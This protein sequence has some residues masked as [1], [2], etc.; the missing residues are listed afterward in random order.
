[1]ADFSDLATVLA[2][3][4]RKTNPYDARRRYGYGMLQQGMDTSPIASPWQGAARLAQA[5]AGGWAIHNADS[6]EKVADKKR[7]DALAQ[8]MAEPDPQKRIGL[9]AAYDPD[10]GSRMAG[11]LA[12][13][14]YK[15]NAQR[16]Q[17]DTTLARYDMPGGQPQAT[18]MPAQLPTGAPPAGGFNNNAGNIRVTGSRWAGEGAPHNGFKTFATPQDGVNAMVQ[19]YTAY[20]KQNPQIT[21]AQALSKWAPPNENNTGSYIRTITEATGINPGMPLAELMQDPAAFAYFM[22]AQT[23]LEKGGVPQGMTPD[24]F[25]NAAQPRP[26]TPPAAVQPGGL[27]IN[28]PG[29][30]APAPLPVGGAAPPIAGG[31]GSAEIGG[32]PPAPSPQGVSG[33][34][35][36]AQPPAPPQRM[37][38]AD[39]PRNVLAPYLQR[40]QQGGYGTN[41]AEAEQRMLAHV[42]QDLDRSYEAQKMEYEQRYGDF[43]FQR[44]QDANDR[45]ARAERDAKAPQEAFSNEKALR[46]EFEAQ[47]AVKSYRVVVPM[48]ES[49][50]EAGMTRAGD[51]N[52]IYAFAKLM[53]PDSVVRE[54]ETGAV[55]ATQSVADRLQA[56]IGQLNGQPMLNAE[57]RA[58]LLAE[59]DSRFRGIKES[60]DQLADQYGQIAKAHGLEPGRV[61]TT[62]RPGNGRGME[63]GNQPSQ[64]ELRRWGQGGQ[65]GT[66][67]Q[68]YGMDGKPL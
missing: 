27:Q 22:E 58:K 29:P 40:F 51:L 20:V 44:E 8:A 25:T 38:A 55:V 50:K 13:E 3:G 4:G 60:H 64:D 42:Q 18:G 39:A 61:I 1:M 46:G 65:T 54:S 11:Q 17:F 49:A 31:Q 56:Y 36:T 67:R 52:L 32:M 10:V 66:K 62:I 59:L 48:L 14:Q 5:L 28:M 33:P 23:R 45:R 26:Q 19:N 6:E 15:Q 21:I 41:A 24:H 7:S 12:I 47:P 30:G 16:G 57:T 2:T 34:T 9:L 43:K 35:V 37:N 68:V 63:T 53:D